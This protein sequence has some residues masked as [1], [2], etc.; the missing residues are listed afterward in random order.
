[1]IKDGFTQHIKKF[2]SKGNLKHCTYPL[3]R[4]TS[5]CEFKDKVLSLG[6]D[7]LSDIED[8]KL[9][10]V[11]ASITVSVVSDALVH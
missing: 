5:W 1:M 8:S 9:P 10:S 2:E 6:G 4:E 11:A 3:G 7:S